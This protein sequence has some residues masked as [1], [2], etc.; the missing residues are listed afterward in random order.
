MVACPAALCRWRRCFLAEQLWFMTRIREKEEVYCRYFL[1]A[2]DVA[3][4]YIWSLLAASTRWRHES[5]DHS[6]L[7]RHR[8]R[9]HCH[10]QWRYW[11]QST[12]V[13]TAKRHSS[14]CIAILVSFCLSAGGVWG[15]AG[16]QPP[17]PPK[18]VDQDHKFLKV[19]LVLW[20]S[21][22]QHMSNPLLRYTASNIGVP[23]KSGSWVVQGHWKWR[24]SID[25]TTYYWSAIATIAL[26]CT[27]VKLPDV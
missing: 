22:S 20:L 13:I 18:N 15:G 24:R 4:F 7:Y 3:E 19:D 11:F 25:H 17:F 27:I 23:F 2:Y 21:R 16:A 9:G 10:S 14:V 8:R 6:H 1:A 26:S 12:P 5:R